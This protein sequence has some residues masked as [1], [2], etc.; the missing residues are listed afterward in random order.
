[1]PST[2]EPISSQTLGSAASIVTFSDI[3]T[4]Y[5]DLRLIAVFTDSNSYTLLRF[6][7]DSNNNYSRTYLSNATP[8]RTSNISSAYLDGY[9]TG[10]LASNIFDIFSYASPNVFKSCLNSVANMGGSTE[11]VRHSYLWRSTSAITSISIIS[12]NSTS[13]IASGSTFSLYGIKAA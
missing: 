10:P 11:V 6:N 4:I 13:S 12:P 3:P 7:S 5:T 9:N 8:G 1:M 2:Y